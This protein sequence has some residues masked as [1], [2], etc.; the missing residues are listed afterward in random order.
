MNIRLI[1]ESLSDLARRVEAIGGSND[2]GAEIKRLSREQY[3]A[4]TLAEQQAEQTRR[5][6]E[7][8]Q[9]AL[10]ELKRQQEEREQ[11]A[12]LEVVTALLPLMDSIEAGIASG[13]S[14][15]KSLMGLHPEAA[16]AL[17]A[18]LNGQR[19]LR[20]RLLALLNAEGVSPLTAKGQMFDPHL[21]VAV[22]VVNHPDLPSGQ[23]VAEERR[24]YKQ[25]NTILRYAE[26]IVNKATKE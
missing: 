24:G 7:Q 5:A 23:I 22:K 3:K 11:R 18:W 15:A 21:H 1:Y 25:E 8:S 12:R 17:A 19:L 14:Q 20:E 16:Q 4:N 26:V 9:Q 2:A 10:D 13:A 6:L